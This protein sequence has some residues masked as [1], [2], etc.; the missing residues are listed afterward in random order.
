[1][2]K[3]KLNKKDPSLPSDFHFYHG[4]QPSNH[5]YDI[6]GETIGD[7]FKPRCQMV[8]NCR[9]YKFLPPL[10]NI[11]NSD[12]H[13]GPAGSSTQGQHPLLAT[14]WLANTHSRPCSFTLCSP[15][16]G[17]AGGSRTPFY[18][19]FQLPASLS[20]SGALLVFILTPTHM[21]CPTTLLLGFCF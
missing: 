19:M 10:C 4:P 3:C 2:W 1:M 13:A 15:G 7:L 21:S 20:W 5:S 18:G 17:E 8:R 16:G 6:S 12:L 11:Q 9:I 14:P